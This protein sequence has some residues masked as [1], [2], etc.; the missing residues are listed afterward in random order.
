MRI[1]RGAVTGI[2]DDNGAFLREICVDGE[3]VFRGVGFLAR[4]E[5]WGTPPLVALR[6]VQDA[7]ETLCV[8]ASGELQVGAADLSWAVSWRIDG[9]VIEARAEAGSREGF[10]TNRTGFVVLHSLGAT[11]ARAVRVTHP[12]GSLEDTA[13][14]ALVSPHQ[15]FFEIA[16]LE[17]QTDAGHRLRV[18]FEGEIFEIEDQRNWTDASYKT[19]C[20]PLRLP[21]PYRIRPGAAVKQT[22][23]IEVLSRAARP[24]V[25]PAS[26]LSIGVTQPLPLIGTS[27]PPGVMHPNAA[28]A[29]QRLRLGFTAIEIDLADPRALEGFSAKLAACPSLVRVDI[30]PAPPEAGLE[31]VAAVVEQ[32]GR[33]PLLGITLW[34]ADDG[35]LAA[36]RA[37]APGVAFGAGS[38]AF[39]TELN[40]AEPLP[41]TADYLSWPASP[42]VHG[43][44]DDTIGETTEASD[45]IRATITSKAPGKPLHLGPLTLGMRFN[46]VASTLEGRRGAAADPRQ[47]EV[48][49]AAWVIATLIGHLHPQLA[50]VAAF[51][52][53]GPKGLIDEA[54]AMTPAGHALRRLARHSGRLA[55]ALRWANAPRARGLLIDV[56]GGAELC[57]AYARADLANLP[58]PDGA[59]R[60]ERLLKSGFVDAGSLSGSMTADGFSLAWLTRL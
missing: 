18:S 58:L 25:R 41:L 23:R 51:E 27:L 4:D 24:F 14:P 48:I 57:I 28:T 10:M 9:H 33:R 26:S 55:L 5:N 30:R 32:F 47:G 13:F 59:W 38:P 43:V 6:W 40:R 44:S 42:T 39:F 7:D 16:A 22:V 3:E 50:T 49:T 19:Y 2:F 17:Y 46:P 45:D 56:P 35:Q 15:P 36:A 54:G 37:L 29:P 21:Y 8:N 31:A 52:P 34:G 20:R 12:D 53:S 1:E 11:R 60:V